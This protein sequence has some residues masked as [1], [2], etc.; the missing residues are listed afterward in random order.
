MALVKPDKPE[1]C[2]EVGAEYEFVVVSREVSVRAPPTHSSVCC[3][4]LFAAALRT[5]EL[6]SPL[7]LL[8]LALHQDENGQQMLSRRR[9]LFGQAWDR[10][11]EMYAN[12]EVVEG[13]VAAVNRGGAMMVV[14]GLRAFLPGSHF[15]AGQ[16]R[17]APPQQE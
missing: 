7:P 1:N 12:D 8:S 3:A 4:F 15:L 16:V 13:E 11:A 14:E 17:S 9:I 10:V 6:T 2:L 5:R